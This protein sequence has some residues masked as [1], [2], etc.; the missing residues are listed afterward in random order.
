MKINKNT[1]V[2]VTY[3]P[4]L[5]TGKVPQVAEASGGE[6]RVDVVFEKGGKKV[7]RNLPTESSC[8]SGG[9]FSPVSKR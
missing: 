7:F 9:Y 4:E 2:K 6:Y 3:R 5:G 8:A 1:K